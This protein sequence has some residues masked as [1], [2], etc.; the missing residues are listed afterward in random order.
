MGFTQP[1]A[2]PIAH[3][4]I[5]TYPRFETYCLVQVVQVYNTPLITDSLCEPPVGETVVDVVVD[6]VVLRV[7]VAQGAVA[8]AAAAAA[9]AVVL[10]LYAPLLLQ[11]GVVPQQLVSTFKSGSET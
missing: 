1:R 6:H 10:L 4:C 3:L 7:V 8:V 5:E 9:V 11:V 2:H